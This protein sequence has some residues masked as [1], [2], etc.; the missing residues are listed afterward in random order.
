MSKEQFCQ[1][2]GD[3]GLIW[4]DGRGFAYCG[5]EQ[6]RALVADPDF[7]PDVCKI[8]PEPVY[9]DLPF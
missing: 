2:C 9:H 8:F 7:S 3:S 6:G 4:Q 1:L 5:C